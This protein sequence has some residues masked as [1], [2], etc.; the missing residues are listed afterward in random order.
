MIKVLENRA[1]M[2]DLPNEQFDLDEAR[3]EFMEEYEE[4]SY[5]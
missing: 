4:A 2:E 3:E 5:V 1:T